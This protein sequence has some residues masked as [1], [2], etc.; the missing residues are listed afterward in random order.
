LTLDEGLVKEEERR[1]YICRR[2]TQE[3]V[4]LEQRVKRGKAEGKGGKAWTIADKS[5][6]GSVE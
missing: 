5:F 2:A 6:E 3:T 1:I 4:G